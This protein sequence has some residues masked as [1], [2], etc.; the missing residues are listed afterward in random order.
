MH[1]GPESLVKWIVLV[2]WRAYL[3]N[4]DGPCLDIILSPLGSQCGKDIALH[5]RSIC[6]L[7]LSSYKIKWLV[8]P[9]LEKERSLKTERDA[10]QFET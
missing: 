9:V 8:V 10:K 5:E 2:E 4:K 1:V 6:P 7:D 3:G